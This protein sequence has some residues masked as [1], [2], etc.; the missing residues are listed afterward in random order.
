M[1]ILSAAKPTFSSTVEWQFGRCSLGATVAAGIA[2]LEDAGWMQTGWG[3]SGDTR[4][5]CN[6]P[7]VFFYY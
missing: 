6:L 7:N 1:D 3:R 2:A 5:V 4:C